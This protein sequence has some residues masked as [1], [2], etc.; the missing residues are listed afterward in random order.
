VSPDKLRRRALALGAQIEIDGKTINAG[1]Q[2]LRVASTR[3]AAAAPAPEARQAA[4]AGD[5][6]A[7][8]L[9]LH[10]RVSAQAE[11]TT[12]A[13]AELVS[14]V[15]A[16]AAPPA[17]EAAPRPPIVMPVSFAVVR[18]EEGR[19]QRL[20]PTYGEVTSAEL[21]GLKPLHNDN[22]LIQHITPRYAGQ[23]A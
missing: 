10:T 21:V 2:Q 20:E 22:G 17:P 12:R 8:A 1:R 5:T 19:A 7:Q 15:L 6:M 3:L 18:D 23:T 16:A 14:N 9:E 13:L 11:A 4:P